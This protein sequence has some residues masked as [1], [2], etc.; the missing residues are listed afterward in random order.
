MRGRSFASW[1]DLPCVAAGGP[2]RALDGAGLCRVA[3]LL[4]YLIVLHI[5]LPYVDQGP[6]PYEAI[7]AIAHG[8]VDGFQLQLRAHKIPDVDRHRRDRSVYC[9][10]GSEVDLGILE[11]MYVHSAAAAKSCVWP[12]EY[13]R[14]HDPLARPAGHT[15]GVRAAVCRA[16]GR[17]AWIGRQARRAGAGALPR[18]R[19]RIQVTAAG[20]VQA[21]AVAREQ[22]K[23]IR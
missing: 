11:A 17:R 5:S 16:T 6:G 8:A 3:P 23:L 2:D 15:A 4:L 22:V 18:R 21:F 14:T 10:H 9:W 20:G 1:K 12:S 19:A 7:N 13:P